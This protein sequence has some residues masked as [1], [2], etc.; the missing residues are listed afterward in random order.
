[1]RCPAG[2]FVATGQKTRQPFHGPSWP[3]GRKKTALELS[4][5][6]IVALEPQSNPHFHLSPYATGTTISVAIEARH[7]G[8]VFSLNDYVELTGFSAML[9][10]IAA[11]TQHASMP[12]FEFGAIPPYSKMGPQRYIL[13]S[14][15]WR[16]FFDEEEF[17]ALKDLLS[18]FACAPC[19][20]A[21]LEKLEM[22]Y[23]KL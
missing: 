5:I 4:M 11:H 13:G 6:E 12:E 17:E 3:D 1:M 8:Y 16:L 23:G 15:R 18:G 14:G 10:R 9:G 19:A 2:A 22:I 7:H 20:A 21:H